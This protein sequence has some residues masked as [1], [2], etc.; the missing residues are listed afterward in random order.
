M[1]IRKPFCIIVAL[2]LVA[3]TFE[4]LYY[5]PSALKVIFGL[6]ITGIIGYAYCSLAGLILAV[7]ITCV[8]GLFSLRKRSKI[9]KVRIISV[10][11]F[12][13]ITLLIY[14]YCIFF[15]DFG[16]NELIEPSQQGYVG[17]VIRS[18]GQRNG[19]WYNS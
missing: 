16:S 9:D 17:S 12:W 19:I 10:L 15:V 11:A 4:L 18:L 3:W 13:V 7:I 14:L 1:S 5:F 2:P 8:I 6:N